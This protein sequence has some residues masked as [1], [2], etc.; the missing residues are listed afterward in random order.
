MGPA[1]TDR[2]LD[3]PNLAI[4]VHHRSARL[5]DAL[6]MVSAPERDT[7]NHACKVMDKGNPVYS[8]VAKAIVCATTQ[9]LRNATI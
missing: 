8:V 1:Q 9:V 7:R 6:Q 4:R 5:Y 3:D 2:A